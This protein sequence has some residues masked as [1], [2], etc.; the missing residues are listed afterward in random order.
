MK[1]EVKTTGDLRQLLANAIKGVMNGQMDLDR[2]NAVHKIAKNLSDSLY[3]ET[4]IAMF[5]HEIGQALD[6]FGDLP[7][8][9]SIE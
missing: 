4:K 8:Y 5:R 7:L 6:K 9:G 2:A 3:S 1:T